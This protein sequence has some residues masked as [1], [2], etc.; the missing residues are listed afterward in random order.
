[1][2]STTGKD[3]LVTKED[4]ADKKV[5]C[6]KPKTNYMTNRCGGQSSSHIVSGFPAE[7][8]RERR[9]RPV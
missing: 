4:L 3:D 9:R 1:L 6:V 7:D 2:R 5:V 8:G